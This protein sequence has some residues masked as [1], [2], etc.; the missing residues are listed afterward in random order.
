M[1]LAVLVF[2]LLAP[3]QAA[4]VDP[5][6]DP[7]CW[8]K[9]QC[10][11]VGGGFEVDP[12][13]QA[14]N[15]G[16]CYAQKAIPIQVKLPGLEGQ[17]VRDIGQY[18]TI[19]FVWAVR[20]AAVLAVVVIMAGGVM[21][22]TSGGAERLGKAKELIGNAVIGLL[23]AVGSYVVLQTIN[24][25]LVRLSLP[26]MRMV[27]AIAAGSL[28]CSGVPAEV[29]IRNGGPTGSV[30][31]PEARRSLQCGRVGHTP[32]A[33]AKTCL[34]DFCDPGR[35]CLPGGTG[36]YECVVGT[37]GGEVGGDG[38][39]FLDNNIEL[40]VACADGTTKVVASADGK[41]IVERRRHS[42]IFSTTSLQICNVAELCGP[43][44]CPAPPGMFLDVRNIKGFFF[45][46]EVNEDNANDDWYAVGAQSCG[47]ASKPL[48]ASPSDEG[49]P[50][51]IFWVSVPKDEF[52]PQQT[53][54]DAIRG[55]NSTLGPI[56]PFR[57]NLALNRS[58]FPE[59]W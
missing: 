49:D 45:R 7:T 42:Y 36:G 50:D 52:I 9:Q 1:A 32:T 19:M 29:E 27:R 48:S 23:L 8:P 28:F 47:G 55:P 24:P 38:D 5:Q 59:R 35:V 57:C 53:I 56:V 25:D 17:E 3:F 6:L 41:Q 51:K 12:A 54:Y 18:I 40:R 14:E 10:E 13:C 39:A 58:N 34:G 11:G 21:W 44:T 20:V 2:M 33:S 26:R 46:F 30:Y 31:H 22:L 37:I 15:F 43:A 4:A 16:R